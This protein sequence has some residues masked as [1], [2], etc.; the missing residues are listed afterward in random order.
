MSPVDVRLGLRANAGQFALL[1][2]VNAFVGAM[3][4]LERTILPAL[5]E[6]EFNLAARTAILS[7]I[8]AF[9]ATKAL[10][11]FFAGRLTDRVGRKP[12]LVAGWLLALPV[13]LLLIWAPTWAWVVAAN[14]LLGASQGL[15]WSTTVVMKIDLVGPRQRGLA[16]GLNESSGYLA[17]AAAALASGY[18]AQVWGLRPAPFL[19]GVAF[20]LIG[21]L[22]SI[23]VIRETRQHAALETKGDAPDRTMG[24]VFWRTSFADGDLG[25]ACRAGFANNLNDGL[26]WG[27][28]PLWFASHG[29]SLGDIAWLAGLYPAVWGAGQL[30]TGALSDHVGR[31]PL[32]AAGM[33]L[34]AAALTAMALS[35]TFAWFAAASAMLGLGTAL[36]Y[37]TLLAAI[38]DASHPAERGSVIGVYRLWRDGGYVA[39]AVVAGLIADAMGLSAA[40]AAVALLTL[41]SG[42]EVAARMVAGRGTR[43]IGPLLVDGPGG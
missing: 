15:T 5:A 27:L 10:A 4:G 13:P 12:V 18:A 6:Q 24:V 32:I 40:I 28:F 30:F 22:L 43:C 39:G 29:L 26:A 38:G 11:N 37:P 31:K 36:V 35:A 25:M 21:L 41:L 14:V 9:G 3:V 17:V 33:T 7:F 19:L 8:A 16:M 20:A 1:L 34:Q 23:L 2:L 42:G